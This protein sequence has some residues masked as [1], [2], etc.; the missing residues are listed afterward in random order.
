MDPEFLLGFVRDSEGH[1]LPRVPYRH[2]VITF[3]RLM[4]IW[5]SVREDPTLLRLLV[6]LSVGV[7]TRE[8]R[9]EVRA[10]R[11]RREELA[12]ALPGVV[13]A[14]QSAGDSLQF[15]PHG[16]F[17]ITDGVFLP[18]GV[19]YGYLAWDSGRLTA[20]LRDSVLVS[21]SEQWSGL[22]LLSPEAAETMKSWPI[23]CSGFHV[24]VETRVEPDDREHLRTLLKYLTRSPVALDRLHYSEQTGQVTYRTKKGATLHTSDR[25]RTGRPSCSGPGQGKRRRA[26]TDS[27]PDGLVPHRPHLRG[28]SRRRRATDPSQ[29]LQGSRAL[30][31]RTP[32]SSRG[33][34]DE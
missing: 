19:F 10:H 17:L 33:A 27:G 3:P 20:P 24:H 22:G 18:S 4:G 8:L 14:W 2:M 21:R 5:H 11:H 12:A 30:C 25:R 26:E 13:A 9:R 32:P 7:V 16:P 34:H 31:L 15:H 6:R 23:E 1:P 28:V 29:G